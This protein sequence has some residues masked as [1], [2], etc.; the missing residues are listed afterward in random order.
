MVITFTYMTGLILTNLLNDWQYRPWKISSF[1]KFLFAALR[2][3]PNDPSQL[4]FRSNTPGGLFPSASCTVR[5]YKQET[6][7]CRLLSC[8]KLGI[9]VLQM[10][11]YSYHTSSCANSC[12]VKTNTYNKLYRC[13][14]NSTTPLHM[15]L[16]G[17]TQLLQMNLSHFIL[18]FPTVI[19]MYQTEGLS[20]VFK[21][22]ICWSRQPFDLPFLVLKYIQF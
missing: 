1:C 7:W 11:C 18:K 22:R 16:I 2:H 15:K 20:L 5:M 19:K 8:N 21:C 3:T 9:G 4:R 14:V 17:V 6:K 12:G 13:G 10:W